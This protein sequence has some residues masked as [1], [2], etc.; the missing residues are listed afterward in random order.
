MITT[1]NVTSVVLLDFYQAP[2]VQTGWTW[3]MKKM[4]GS[5]PPG[6]EIQ[7]S[8]RI[9]DADGFEYKTEWDVVAFDDDNHT[10]NSLTDGNVIVYWY[11]EDTALAQ[12]ILDAS[13]ATLEALTRD[14]G[15]HIGEIVKLFVYANNRDLL[16]AMLY[17][18]EWT[19]GGAVSDFSTILIPV[20]SDDKEWMNRV[21]AHEFAHIVTHS[22]TH[23]PYNV[24]PTWLDE[25]ISTYAEGDLRSDFEYSLNR[26]ISADSLIRLKTLSSNFP[27]NYDEAILSYAESYSVVKFLIDRYGNDSFLALLNT[28]KQ[29]SSYDDA[30]IKVYGVDTESIDNLWR[31]SLG[32]QPRPTVVETPEPT[33]TQTSAN[34]SFGCLAL[35]D[36]ASS[37]SHTVFILIGLVLIPGISCIYHL[38]RNRGK[39]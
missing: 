24:I 34:E 29:G 38:S 10:W 16:D 31:N 14:M 28:F 9:I 20:S 30:L 8:W 23:N 12:T 33:P 1:A 22:M 18:Q 3:E 27:V 35:T 26:A 11:G 36:T 19:G 6:A 4:L 2:S 25:G 15:I 5:L 7:Y 37:G 17:P 21:V 13:S 39:R 32:L